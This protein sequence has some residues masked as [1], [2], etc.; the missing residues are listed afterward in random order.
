MNISLT[1][2]QELILTTKA[3]RDGTTIDEMIAVKI[4]QY[5]TNSSRDN[6]YALANPVV[7]AEDVLAL[8][9]PVVNP[10]NVFQ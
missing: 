3:T 1:E 6:E 4:G 7:E 5:V 10:E 2:A 8:V 9:D